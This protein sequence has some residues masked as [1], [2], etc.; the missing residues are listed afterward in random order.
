MSLL[1]LAS[2]S[3]AQVFNPGGA[4]AI[5]PGP[6]QALPNATSNFPSP[7]PP[8]YRGNWNN[9]NNTAPAGQGPAARTLVDPPAQVQVSDQ[10][11]GSLLVFPYYTSDAA[12]TRNTWATIS[13]ISNAAV[14]VHIFF[15][16]GSS[17]SQADQFICLTANASIQLIA[18]SFDPLTTGWILAV[19]VDAAGNPAQ[20]NV[21]IGNAFVL[22]GSYSGNYGAEA[23][24][25]Y[26]NVATAG[27]PGADITV[28][29]NPPGNLPNA[30]AAATTPAG[31][32]CVANTA[33]GYVSGNGYLGN[34]YIPGLYTGGVGTAQLN[35]T[36]PPT[37]CWA[38]DN[39]A[40]QTV[41]TF[42][43]NGGGYDF[44][45]NRFAVEIQSPV[46]SPNQRIVVVGLD[47]DISTATI[48]SP[49]QLGTGTVINGNETPFGSFVNFTSGNCQRI[50]DITA[51]NPRVPRQMSVLIPTGQVGVM[52][53][54]INGG[55]VGLIMTASGGKTP[56][57]IR[58]LHKTNVNANLV[59]TAATG[60]AAVTVTDQTTNATAS[61]AATVRYGVALTIPTFTPPTCVNP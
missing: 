1:T 21:L 48:T 18:N 39:D 49:S 30:F 5:P 44:A 32:G 19:A 17:C 10:K 51:T 15:L 3:F 52:Q 6:G 40:L 4:I 14:L 59:A 29:P 42:Q 41:R 22:D 24:T 27:A 57:G 50:G 11:A 33:A 43:L 16:Q 61:F 20:R 47:G 13:N 53:W 35:F 34:G 7:Q 25:A 2:A 28:N 60:A 46:D 54:A 45:P 58:T 55:G 12:G 37:F 23:F 36:G 9:E 56:A 31:P 8:G 26:T 38:R